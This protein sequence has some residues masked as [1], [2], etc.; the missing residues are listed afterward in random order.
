MDEMWQEEQM[1]GQWNSAILSI[2]TVTTTDKFL[3]WI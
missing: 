3:S 2:Q 1:P